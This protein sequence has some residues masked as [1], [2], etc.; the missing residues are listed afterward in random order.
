[1]EYVAYKVPADVD[2]LIYRHQVKIAQ[3]RGVKLT[4]VTKSGD[5]LR[6]V[7]RLADV[8]ESLTASGDTDAQAQP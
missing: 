1:M 4:K 2:A 3:R 5:V 7:L 8:A 6:E